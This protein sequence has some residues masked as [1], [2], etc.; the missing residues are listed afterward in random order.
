MPKGFLIKILYAF[1]ISSTCATQK[2]Q[3]K[4]R[5]VMLRINSASR[6]Y[7]QVKDMGK[8]RIRLKLYWRNSF[9]DAGNSV[10]C[11]RSLRWPT[12]SLLSWKFTI[13]NRVPKRVNVPSGSLNSSP[14]SHFTVNLPTV[15]R[16]TKWSLSLTF[17]HQ[18]FVY[19]LV[20]GTCLVNVASTSYSVI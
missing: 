16:S 15:P 18:N 7:A 12:D 5:W 2:Q 13:H 9:H 1:L 3:S 11:W 6:T 19:I 20:S 4:F 8:I 10:G 17:S 14:P